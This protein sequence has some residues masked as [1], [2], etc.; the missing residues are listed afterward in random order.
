MT[1]PAAPSSAW[2]LLHQVFNDLFRFIGALGREL[3]F[4][5]TGETPAGG[6]A[7]DARGRP[8]E[9]FGDRVEHADLVKVP[10]LHRDVVNCSFGFREHAKHLPRGHDHLGRQRF[11]RRW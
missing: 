11:K 1:R 9:D 5:Q 3:D 2:Q 8:C 7:R 4:K 10:N 6:R